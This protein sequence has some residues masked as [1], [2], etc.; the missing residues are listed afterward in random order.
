MGSN[1][2]KQLVRNLTRKPIK[3]TQLGRKIEYCSIKVLRQKNLFKMLIFS[4]NLRKQQKNF[5][6]KLI[7]LQNYIM[8]D[9]KQN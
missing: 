3:I 2:V 9:F 5:R 8:R 1:S 4:V 6:I 7:M